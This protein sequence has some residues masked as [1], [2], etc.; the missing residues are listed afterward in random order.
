[1]RTHK[2]GFTLV[3]LMLAMAF[4]SVLLLAIALTAIQAGK[5]YSRGT[6][7]RNINQSGRNISDM[8]KRDF[9]Q[10]NAQKIA[11]D[12]GQVIQVK[13][14][15]GTV[16]NER[17]CLGYYSYIWNRVDAIV[18]ATGDNYIQQLLVKYDDADARDVAINLV[19][20][21][22]SG[23]NLCRK[24]G[25]PAVYP[26]VVDRDIATELLQSPTDENFL[27]VYDFYLNKIT[28]GDSSEALFAL[29]FTLGTGRTGE[30]NTA[31]QSCKPPADDESNMEFCAINKFETIVRTNG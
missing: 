31:D 14:T 29:G 13:T 23:G 1:M 18:R 16:V 12:G 26:K 7:L 19:R 9:L 11:D 10:S 8:L 21:V 24:S 2:Q 27:G 30:I 20:V 4:V 28:S 22:D 25:T 15:D 3:E 6:T 17:I 5:L